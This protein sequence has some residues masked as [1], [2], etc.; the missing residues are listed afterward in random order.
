MTYPGLGE[1]RLK[2]RNGGLGIGNFLFERGIF[3][4]E[5]GDVIPGGRWII[6]DVLTVGEVGR[7][8]S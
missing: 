2:F 4:L 1:L 3:G 6:L 5:R 7:G 8:Q